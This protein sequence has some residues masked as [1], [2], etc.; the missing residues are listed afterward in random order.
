MKITPNFIL[1][2]RKHLK[3]QS[4][5]LIHAVIREL[6]KMETKGTFTGNLQ[7]DVDTALMIIEEKAFHSLERDNE[8]E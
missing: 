2:V 4:L 3:G 6:K 5:W 1:R 7:E 8:N